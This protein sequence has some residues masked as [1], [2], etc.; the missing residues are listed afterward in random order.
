MNIHKNARLAPW[1][2]EAV[3][4]RVSA[5][6]AKSAVARELGVSRQTIHKWCTRL[7]QNAGDG[8]DRSSRPH[9]SPTQLPR[10]KRRQIIKARRK[11]WSSLRIAQHYDIAI[12]TVV[13][14]LRRAGLHTL[15]VRS[16]TAVRPP[17]SPRPCRAGFQTPR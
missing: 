11:R 1:M 3:V 10:T 17:R 4:A 16:G 13:T 8:G 7:G 9:R 14:H 12:S 15:G 2:R 5:G 6:E